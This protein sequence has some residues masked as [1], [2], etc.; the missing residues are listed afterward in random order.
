M[1]ELQSRLI[2]ILHK[3]KKSTIFNDE[4]V[5]TTRIID[6]IGIDSLEMINLFLMIEDEFN[7]EIEYTAMELSTL[8]SVSTLS[9]FIQSQIDNQ[10]DTSNYETF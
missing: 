7:I 10:E 1:E 2:Y 6:D 9:A 4:I 8:E 5:G 3:I